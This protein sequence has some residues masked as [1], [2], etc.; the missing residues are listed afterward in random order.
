MRMIRGALSAALPLLL[1]SSPW[2]SLPGGGDPVGV[3]TTGVVLEGGGG[4][5]LLELPLVPGESDDP[6][7]SAM[8]GALSWESL[9]GE[10]LDE[11]MAAY[12][13]CQRGYIGAGFTVGYD[14]GGILS[15]TIRIQYYGA[16]PSESVRYL[17]FDTS[18][19][20]RL[21]I[22]DLIDSDRVDSLVSLLDSMLQENIAAEIESKGEDLLGTDIYE[23]LTFTEDDLDFFSIEGDG[24]RFHYEFGFPHAI[25]AAEPDGDLFIPA[26][27]FLPFTPVII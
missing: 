11:T 3:L 27:E 7:V 15:I 17:C 12:E 20:D 5:A 2:I 1:T 18:T 21:S 13:A 26:S 8:N 22:R 16:Y 6:A 14:R 24:I 9:T 4:T 23:G 10:P 19:G 25:K